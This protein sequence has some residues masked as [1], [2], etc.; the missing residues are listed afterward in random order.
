MKI[1]LAGIITLYIVVT[2]L[3]ITWG[4]PSRNI[5]KY[6]FGGG[7]VWSGEKIYR[8][9]KA[10]DKLSPDRASQTGADVDVDPL[11]KATATGE[12]IPLT[13]TDEDI[14]RIYLRYRLYTHQPDEMITMMALAGMR[15]SRLQLD[16][17]LA[18]DARLAGGQLPQVSLRP[19]TRSHDS[20]PRRAPLRVAAKRST[21]LLARRRGLGLLFRPPLGLHRPQRVQRR[22]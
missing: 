11:Q 22:Q 10:E 13:A 9:A 20:A 21:P 6:L 4:L 19:R 5:D 18:V 2:C 7:E 15:P 16:P 17:R 1:R 8:L 12:P 3:G 14:A